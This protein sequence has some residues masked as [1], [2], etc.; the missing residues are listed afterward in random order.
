MME[1][2][3]EILLTREGFRYQRYQKTLSLQCKRISPRSYRAGEQ[4]G[5]L[6]GLTLGFVAGVMG[7]CVIFGWC[8][9]TS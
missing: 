2:F 3:R 4:V 5:L 1:V 8:M 9:P 7:V 6:A